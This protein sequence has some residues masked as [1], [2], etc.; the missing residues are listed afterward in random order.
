MQDIVLTM[1]VEDG[2]MHTTLWK[3]IA[4]SHYVSGGIK[5]L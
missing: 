4:S 5:S 1:F 2:R 3:H